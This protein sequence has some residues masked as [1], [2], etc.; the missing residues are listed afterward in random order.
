MSKRILPDLA[1]AGLALCLITA[2]ADTA[3]ATGGIRTSWKNRYTTACT[4]LRS[5]ADACVLCHVSGDPDASD[6]NGYGQSLADNNRNFAAIEPVDSDGDGRTNLLEI[7]Q[8][9]TFPGDLAS[10]ADD[11]SWGTLK[12]TYR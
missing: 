10:P 1:M 3:R 9:C 4:T 2:A 6:L 7:T 5:A 12:A 11:P 8:D